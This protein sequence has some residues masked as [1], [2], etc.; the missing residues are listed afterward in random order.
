[1]RD[2]ISFLCTSNG[3]GVKRDAPRSNRDRTGEIS[4]AQNSRGST[5]TL[6]VPVF[7]PSPRARAKVER[8][9]L[10]NLD[11]KPRQLGC[12]FTKVSPRTDVS[13]RIILYLPCRWS[14]RCGSRG[15]L[16]RLGETW[17]I[18]VSRAG[19]GSPNLPSNLFKKIQKRGGW[20]GYPCEFQRPNSRGPR[21]G[22][23]DIFVVVCRMARPCA[24]GTVDLGNQ[25]T[26]LPRGEY[27]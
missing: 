2:V 20:I 9:S 23:G 1:M 12:V 3:I 4:K 10:S 11:F 27:L 7:S 22:N 18:L 21:A 16:P 8:S 15:S 19:L 24:G 13:V 14:Y 26:P 5:G 6:F 25:S 17:Q